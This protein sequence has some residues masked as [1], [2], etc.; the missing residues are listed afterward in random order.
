MNHLAPWPLGRGPGL[1]STARSSHED[2]G[3]GEEPGVGRGG[4]G[5][6]GERQSVPWK[7]TSWFL[8]SPPS[9]MLPAIS[10]L[11][12]NCPTPVVFYYHAYH[13]QKERGS[14]CWASHCNWAK[15]TTEGLF[16]QVPR[17]TLNTIRGISAWS[18]LRT[19]LLYLKWVTVLRG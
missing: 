1:Y 10:Y 15:K 17:T 18:R 13:F 12:P 2:V 9:S 3:G 14:Y 4:A 6:T 5:C 16:P 7:Q 8:L 19:T 11:P